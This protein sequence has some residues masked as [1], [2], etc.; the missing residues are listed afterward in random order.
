MENHLPIGFLLHPIN[1]S[2]TKDSSPL[3]ISASSSFDFPPSQLLSGDLDYRLQPLAEDAANIGAYKPARQPLA[4]G[5]FMKELSA[6][7]AD[8]LKKTLLLS[9]QVETV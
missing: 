3:R 8:S 1:Q 9:F 2:S 6:V 5:A 4:I 7:D